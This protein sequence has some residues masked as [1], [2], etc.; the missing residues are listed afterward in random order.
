VI[1]KKT[2]RRRGVHKSNQAISEEIR[3]FAVRIAVSYVAVM[4]LV[5]CALG[6]SA[7][8]ET[9]FVYGIP[10][11]VTSID[12]HVGAGISEN[13]W[14]AS[15]AYEPL[16]RAWDRD[17][18]QLIPNLAVSWEASEDYSVWTFYLREDVTFHDGEPF[19]AEAVRFTFERLL[20][21]T[22]VDTAY[23]EFADEHSC[24]VVDE[25]TVR[26]ELN[27]SYPLFAFV[28]AVANSACPI[29]PK[30][31][32]EHATP[33][34]PYAFDWMLE[35]ACGTGPFRL[36][37]WQRGQKIVFAK[38]E[39]YWGG[40]GEPVGA[41]RQPSIDRLVYQV[42]A[43]PT[44]RMLTLEAGDIDAAYG[45]TVDQ[46]VRLQDNS[47]IKVETFPTASIVY[48]AFDVRHP[49]FDSVHVRQAISW[50][51]DMDAIIAGPEGG[52][53]DRVYSV[54]HN[55][56][57]GEDSSRYQKYEY[58][59]E[60]AKAL[61]A[62]AGYPDGFSTNLYYAV[63]RR[64]QFDEEAVLIQ[65]YLKAVG[66]KVQVQKVAFPT[67]LELQD[68]GD[69]GLGLCAYKSTLF[70]PEG[71]VGWRIAPDR[72]TEGWDPTHWEAPVAHNTTAAR[73][74]GDPQE[75]ARLYLELA[76]AGAQEAI[77]VPMYQFVEGIAMRDNVQGFYFHPLY[78]PEFWNVTK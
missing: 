46:L 16:V 62:H 55:Q 21:G 13:N 27:Q 44:V 38:N 57:L 73:L 19:N 11:G 25:H 58:D 33:D 78:G 43:D 72:V 47:E 70:D 40:V 2:A 77:Y 20:N 5:G 9:A 49:P 28:D 53:A 12:P 31:V 60:L 37:E 75:R 71:G 56:A 41:P 67:Q 7:A 74:T 52:L 14:V 35:H 63:E 8:Q 26:F 66:I 17:G 36:I 51:I 23:S 69:Y 64:S 50:A 22:G 32:E 24:V 54:L 1:Q 42:I 29:S 6:I 59:P 48:L 61:L 39:S 18:I 30:Y 4:L 15:Q 34:D 76:I 10:A 65:S 3:R 45:L 68:K